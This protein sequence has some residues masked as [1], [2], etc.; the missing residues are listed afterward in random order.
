MTRR[1]SSHRSNAPARVR[2]HA[3]SRLAAQTAAADA[4]FELFWELAFTYLR[5]NSVGQRLTGAYGESPGR[6]SLMRSLENGGPQSVAQIARSRGIARQAI[7]QLADQL[8]ADG[9]IEYLENP[10]HRRVKLMQITPNGGRVLRQMLGKQYGLAKTISTD[11]N[12]NQ[13]R[14][15]VSVLRQLREGLA[16]IFRTS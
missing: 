9:L 15:A 16:Q 4:L 1:L 6:V 5:L 8:C 12:L 13:V 2:P 7:Q 10:A 3:R 14:T 11:F